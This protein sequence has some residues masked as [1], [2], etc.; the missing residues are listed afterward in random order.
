VNIQNT[1]LEIGERMITGLF[2]SHVDEFLRKAGVYKGFH[3]RSR[4][5]Y[6]VEI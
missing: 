6:N 1:T 4:V 3:V 5:K 2:F